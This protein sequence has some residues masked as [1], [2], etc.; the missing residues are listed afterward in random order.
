MT[1]L[2]I[3]NKVLINANLLKKMINGYNA[4][5]MNAK[6]THLVNVLGSML[7]IAIEHRN[8]DLSKLN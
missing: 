1:I 3:Q 8:R 2:Q 6:Y 7:L 4:L 5:G